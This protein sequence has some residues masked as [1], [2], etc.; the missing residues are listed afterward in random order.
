MRNKFV[1]VAASVLLTTS[2][3]A[4]AT[5]ID[6]TTAGSSGNDGTVLF[7][8]VSNQSTGTG[9]FPSFEQ[10]GGNV[11]ATQ[12]YN[13]TVNDVF[14]NASSDQHNHELMF[15]DV[16]VTTIDGIDYVGFILDVNQTGDNPLLSLDDIQVFISSDP[17]QSTTTFTGG[18][19]VDFANSQ[20]VYRLT[21]GT[22]IRL[23]FALNSGSGSGD[24]T[25]L[26]PFTFFQTA[27]NTFYGGSPTA[28]QENGSFVYLYSAFG[29][30]AITPPPY[31]N[32][33]G[34]EEWAHFNGAPVGEPPCVPS[35]SNNFCQ[36]ESIPEPMSASLLGAGLLGLGL[37]SLLRRRKG[38]G[39]DAAA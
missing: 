28:A 8:Q 11:T 15:G 32:N 29:G 33:D 38:R 10:I 12:G 35:A 21:S 36:P 13:T 39:S 6:L 22:E 20:E 17:N 9:V 5:L 7:N 19:L 27:F 23:N 3:F 31:P 1:I 14:N 2:P 24:M 34:F 4:Q 30:N 25:M 37:A 26:I 18:G 16:G